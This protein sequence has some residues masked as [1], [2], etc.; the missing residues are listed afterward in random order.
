[1]PDPYKIMDKKLKV[2]FMPEGKAV[3]VLPGTSL[4]EAAGRAGIII[5][6]PCGGQGKCGKCRVEIEESK[7]D[8][9]PAERETLSRD[10]IGKGVRLGC[11]VTIHRDTVVKIPL[12][13]RLFMQN[14]LASGIEDRKEIKPSLWKVYVE[15]EKPKLGDRLSDLE[16]IKEKTTP[17][18]TGIYVIRKLPQ[19]LRS[20][21]FKITCVFSDG[22]LINIE[23][24]NTTDENMGLAFDIGTTTVVGTLLNLNTGQDLAVASRLNPQVVYGDD[25]I[26]RISFAAEDDSNL[27][28]LHY[29]IIETVNEMI[30]E[31]V[32]KAGTSQH[33]IYK[34][35][36]AGNT[37][38]QHL[39]CR[40][41]PAS[42][43]SIPFT[44]VIREPL[45]LKAKKVG[46]EIS[47][48]GIVYVFPCIG[49]FV[50]GDTVSVILTTGM[51]R[52][53]E[54]KLAIDIGTN[55]EI[56]LGNRERLICA[57]TAAGPAFEGARISQGMRASPGAIEKVVI[58]EDVR[59]DA[60]G[61]VPPSGLCGSGLID[62]VAQLLNAGI[63]DSRGR[64]LA[65]AD[66]KGKIPS[67]LLDRIVERKGSNDF[68]LFNGNHDRGGNHV[69]ITQRDVRELQLAKA[70]ISAGVKL[71]K[72]E[73]GISN[74]DI[75]EI[76]LAGAFGNFI[77]RSNAKRI[78]LIPDLPSEKIKFIGNAACSGAKLALLSRNLEKEAEAISSSVE[79][80]ELSRHRD[81]QNEF[82]EAMLFPE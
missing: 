1:M 54:I 10:E 66:L 70:A 56:V 39:F 41:D 58:D 20:A 43:G 33:N 51:N 34:M 78:G 65:K 50:G 21:D 22:E 28:Q 14:I 31:L 79:H 30:G 61:N 80:V 16:R 38:M 74:S 53:S 35:V 72:D 45:T 75:Q 55:G 82:A 24:G 49:G 36:V 12:S 25:V 42:L 57:S 44:P 52:S 76:L 37:G 23:P 46:V 77:R 4:P 60:I 26:S 19:L 47:D 5:S 29:R 62:A 81:F 63:I 27:D 68:R 73:L 8:I 67:P 40:I 71:L 32:K 6:S 69:F 48:D 13:S 2:V 17:F 18:S 59:V 9:T 3:Y 11:Q 64:I 15:L 7:P